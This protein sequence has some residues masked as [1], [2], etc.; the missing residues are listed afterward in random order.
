MFKKGYKMTEEHK[1]KIGEANEISHL[2]LKQSPEHIK[3]R[4]EKMTGRHWTMSEQGRINVSN[5][6]R[7]KPL[8][9]KRGNKSNFWKGGITSI[10]ASIRNLLEY[11]NWRKAVFERDGFRCL[12]CGVKAYEDGVKSLNLNADHIYPFSQYP[13]LRFM[14]ENGRT[15]CEECHKKT[16]TFGYWLH[17]NWRP[18][19][20]K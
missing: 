2:G 3:K 6:K 1:R 17:R 19:V 13:R 11:K 8:L 14:L 10:N 16:L 4:I 9:S 5:A 20:L 15:L 18:K 12:D 7:G